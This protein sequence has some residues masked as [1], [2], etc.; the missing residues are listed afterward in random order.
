MDIP[1]FL[2]VFMGIYVFLGVYGYSWVSGGLR[3][4][5]F[6]GFRGFMGTYGCHEYLWVLYL[7]IKNIAHFLIQEPQKI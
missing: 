2:W 1:R 5:G 6:L 3:V 4:L 7:N